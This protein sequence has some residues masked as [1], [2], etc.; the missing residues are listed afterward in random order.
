MGIHAEQNLRLFR[1][2]TCGTPTALGRTRVNWTTSLLLIMAGVRIVQLEL[3]AQAESSKSLQQAEYDA[4]PM[5]RVRR[6]HP[7]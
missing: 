1:L 4:I 7:A 6:T 5:H 2:P 3:T